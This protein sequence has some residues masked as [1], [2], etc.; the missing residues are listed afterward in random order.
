[1]WILCKLV[2]D[3]RF[4]HSNTKID[5]EIGSPSYHYFCAMNHVEPVLCWLND[6]SDYVFFHVMA[7]SETEKVI[8]LKFICILILSIHEPWFQ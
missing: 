6:V 1:M 7:Y 3:F 8:Y 5:S 2:D 4:R